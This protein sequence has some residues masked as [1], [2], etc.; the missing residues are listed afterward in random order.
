[1]RLLVPQK[2]AY[3]MSTHGSK[4]I[5]FVHKFSHIWQISLRKNLGLLIFLIRQ[6]KNERGTVPLFLSLLG[7][8][9]QEFFLL[10]KDEICATKSQ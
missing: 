5:I 1:M 4:S 10:R 6:A 2:T 7:G 9:L 3:D 8:R